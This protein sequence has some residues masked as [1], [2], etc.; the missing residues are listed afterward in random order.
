MLT[1][2]FFGGCFNPVTK[3][4]IQIA[5]ESIK[6]YKLDKVILVPMGNSYKKEGLLD[7]KERYHMLEIATRDYPQLEISKIELEE[8]KRTMLE[9]F[10]LIKKAYPNYRHYYILG[11]DNLAKLLA[12]KDANELI[13]QYQYIIIERQGYDIKELLE[14]KRMPQDNFYVLVNK[15]HKFTSASRVREEVRTKQEVNLETV[16]DKQVYEYMKE[17]GLYQ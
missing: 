8:E 16:L 4:H 15:E 12:S 5:L 2:G 17:K 9:A 1:Y 11:A 6:Q 10:E 14:E 13:N 3:A 7:A